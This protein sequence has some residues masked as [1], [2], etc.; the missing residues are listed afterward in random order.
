MLWLEAGTSTAQ[1]TRWQEFLRR[2]L[3]GADPLSILRPS[4]A[5]S[6]PTTSPPPPPPPPPPWKDDRPLER[7]PRPRTRLA[8]RL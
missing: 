7:R 4:T 1:R 8:S 3:S 5:D 6:G 2:I